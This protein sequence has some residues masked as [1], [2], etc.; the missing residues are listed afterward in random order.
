VTDPPLFADIGTAGIFLEGINL[1]FDFTSD[2]CHSCEED[3]T[4]EV[5]VSNLNLDF[6][7]TVP[8]AEIDGYSDFSEVAANTL[9]TLGAV[10]RN[11]LK[12]MINHQLLDGKINKL[13]AKILKLIP[14]EID[15]GETGLYIDGW[16]YNDITSTPKAVTIPLKAA[17]DIEGKDYETPCKVQLPSFSIHEG[18]KYSA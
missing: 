6:V 9:N 10:I 4:F 16:L 11:R 2:F 18:S 7:D 12:S 3:S 13:I 15:L 8:I 17:L 1:D 5:L 14:H